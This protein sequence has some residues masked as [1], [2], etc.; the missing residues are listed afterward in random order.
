MK[1]SRGETSFV[2]W[3]ASS[4]H[5]ATP[6][7]TVAGLPGVSLPFTPLRA[8]LSPLIECTIHGSSIREHKSDGYR[9]CGGGTAA[10]GTVTYR[11]FGAQKPPA[12]GKGW[13]WVAG[14]QQPPAVRQK[15]QTEQPSREWSAPRRNACDPARIGRTRQSAPPSHLAARGLPLR[16]LSRAG[17]AWNSACSCQCE[18]HLRACR[19][20]TRDW[21]T[22]RCGARWWPLGRKVSPD[23]AFM[24]GEP[25]LQ[26]M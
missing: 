25:P 4:P 11:T 1:F 17:K 9:A 15:P 26:P 22:R 14:P 19:L 21:P 13:A 5:R 20:S 16:N 12:L 3:R 8:A 23:P 2:S 24:H 10:G 6:P 7:P 18:C